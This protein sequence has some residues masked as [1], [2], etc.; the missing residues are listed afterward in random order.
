MYP[1]ILLTFLT[2]VKSRFEFLYGDALALECTERFAMLLG[3]YGINPQLRPKKQR[4]SASEIGLITYA[5]MIGSAKNSSSDSPLSSL[6]QFLTSRANNLFS[7]VHLLPFFPSSSDDGFSVKDFWSVSPDVGSWQDVDDFAKNRK[8]MF[9]LVLN[10]YSRK[11]SWFTDFINNIAPASDYFTIVDGLPDLSEVVRPRTHPLL[12]AVGTCEGL[13]KVWCT[14]SDDQIDLNYRSPDLLFEILDVLLFY[15]SHGASLIRLD[16]VAFLWKE[17]GTKCIH[18]PQTHQIV[19]L[20]RDL[21]DLVAPDVLLVTETNV[22][23]KENFSYFGNGDEAHLVY[24]FSLAPLLAHALLRSDATYLKKWINSLEPLPDGCSVLNFTASHDGVGLR[25]AS[26]LLPE[27]EI[28]F[29]LQH[30]VLRKGAVSYRAVTGVGNVPYELNIT[31]FALLGDSQSESEA[32]QVKRFLTSQAVMLALQ[33]VPLIYFNSLFGASN[34]ED[35]VARSGH[36]RSIN[37]KKLSS[38]ELIDLIDGDSKHAS[39]FKA[40]K[41]LI[42]VRA[43]NEAFSPES[44]QMVLA[45]TD[46]ILALE[47]G[48]GEQKVT[49]IFNFSDDTVDWPHF[50]S[51][52]RELQD[53]VTGETVLKRSLGPYEFL[54]LQYA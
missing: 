11:G 24:Q 12:T 48:S 15:I 14:F 1:E 21:V 4:L 8:V 19:K 2:H 5:D 6:D 28:Q 53:L 32:R 30:T 26:E 45:T 31:Y 39:I 54:W 41:Q 3:R 34:D 20:L 29:L 22:P 49:C 40:M 35:G 9:D 38:L 16:A 36:L 18:L 47:R 46:S 13:K 17:I 23:H 51:N 27:S 7:F 42:L 10:H 52:S 33:G 43:R 37:R 25:P 50:D 44:A